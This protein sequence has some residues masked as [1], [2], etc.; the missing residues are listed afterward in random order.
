M[1]AL[2]AHKQALGQRVERLN[3][4]ISTVDITISHLKG[5]KEMS[6]KSLF[7][8][9][10]EE[11]EKK[12]TAEAE[13]M[14]DPAIVKASEKKWKSY[15]QEDKQRISEEGEAAYEAIVAAIPLGAASPQAQAGVESW[16]K[17]MDYFWT[18]EPEQLIGLTV[19]YNSDPRFKAN[20]D[21]IDPR[22][23]KFMR[24][25]VKVYVKRMKK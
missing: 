3:R 8:A 11:E 5:K 6:K 18:P 21:K 1:E 14:Y 15:T 7:A 12:Y 13:Q 25:A 24:E 2:R 23:A 10:T 4:L 16:R 17:H 9:F 22:L 20:F 19:L